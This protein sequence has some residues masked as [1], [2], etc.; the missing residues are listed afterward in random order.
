MSCSFFIKHTNYEYDAF[1]MGKLRL[2]LF[3][4]CTMITVTL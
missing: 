1:L 2:A 4:I 3:S